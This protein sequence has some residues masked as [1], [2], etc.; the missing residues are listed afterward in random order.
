MTTGIPD[1]TTE[2]DFFAR[3]MDSLQVIQIARSLKA[4]LERAELKANGLEPRT[5]YTNPTVT[6]FA[7]AVRSYAEQA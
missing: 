2:D 3:G 5:I 6:N 1:L 7:A 4:G